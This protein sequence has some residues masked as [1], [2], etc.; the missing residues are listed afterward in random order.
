MLLLCCCCCCC[1][2]PCC[3][4][5]VASRQLPVIPPSSGQRFGRHLRIM[6]HNAEWSPQYKVPRS[7]GFVD[8]GSL[9]PGFEFR[10]PR[11][12]WLSFA[13]THICLE[14]EGGT[15]G[16]WAAYRESTCSCAVIS[17]PLILPPH[18]RLAF[19]PLTA[20]PPP[21]APH[22]PH[23]LLLLFQLAR[24]FVN[25]S[26]SFLSCPLSVCVCV[27]W[28]VFVSK[29]DKSIKCFGVQ[30]MARCATPLPTN[31]PGPRKIK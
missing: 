21:S 26:S 12:S 7:P 22:F 29:R 27:C 11:S 10:G 30:H 31:P 18:S 16:K 19:N 14:R 15:V 24:L 17:Q 6:T 4:G 2:C 8:S 3:T 20:Q 1:F 5:V 28:C 9:V 23:P 25:H 13:H